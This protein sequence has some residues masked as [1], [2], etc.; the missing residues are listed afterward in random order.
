MS[1]HR[2]RSR[3]LLTGRAF[4][5]GPIDGEFGANS[6]KALNAFQRAHG[7]RASGRADKDVW[8]ALGGGEEAL[9]EYQISEK[10]VAGPFVEEIPQ[11]LKEQ[12]KLDRL[13]YTGPDELLAERFHMNVE[14]L[15]SLNKGKR[16]NEAG[17]SITV[18][19]VGRS[20]APSAARLEVNKKA[21]AVLVFDGQSKLIAFFPATIGSE[22]TPS[23]SGKAQVTRIAHNPAYTYDPAKLDFKGVQ[24]TKKIEIKPGPN[25]PVGVVW[26]ALNKEGYASTAHPILRQSA[27]RNPTAVYV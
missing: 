22:E 7:L 13:S 27:G 20:E 3:S 17:V 24:A 14:F 19:N 8:D 25:N 23:P 12:A 6:K 9:K 21:G 10:D 2:Y 1:T 16:L 4:S 11:T 18:A 15:K 5:P 26:I